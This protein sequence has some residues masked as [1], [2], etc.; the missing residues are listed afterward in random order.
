M[1]KIG[2][3]ILIFFCIC[4]IYAET[5][6][7][8]RKVYFT[9]VSFVDDSKESGL[10]LVYKNGNPFDGNA[11]SVDG[12]SIRCDCM[13]G[14]LFKV[15]VFY[16]SGKQYAIRSVKDGKERMFRQDG[17]EIVNPTKEDAKRF[18]EY[19]KSIWYLMPKEWL[20]DERDIRPRH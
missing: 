14:I 16:P 15:T 12:K 6:Q 2:I 13:H 3:C 4:A 19:I 7:N 11:W 9:E 5:K 20:K 18:S 10:V 1:Q 8:N 17:T